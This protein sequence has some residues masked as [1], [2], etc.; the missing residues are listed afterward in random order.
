[1]TRPRQLFIGIDIGTSGVRALAVTKGGHVAAGVSV[2]MMETTVLDGSGI[3]EQRPDAWWEAVSTATRKLMAGLEEGGHSPD[4]LAAMAVDGTSG[5]L[6][7]LDGGGRPLRPGILYNDVRGAAQADE[8]N[9]LAGDFCRKLGYRF[10]SSY[11]LAKILWVQQ[12]EP[13]VFE[14]TAHLAHPSDYILGCLTGGLGLSDYS[15]AL[16]TG[17][18]LIDDC[19]PPWMQRLPG[20]TQRLP[21]VVPPGTRAGEVSAAAAGET[22]LP[23]GLPVFAGATD[24][25]TA[26]LASGLRKSGDYNTTLGTTLVFK[27]LCRRLCSHPQ[28]LIYCHKLPGGFWLPGAAS[29]TGT[30]WIETWFAQ[31]NIRAVDLAA[32]DMLPSPLV[33]YPLV[34]KGERFPFLNSSAE[35]FCVPEPADRIGRYTASLQGVAMLERMSYQVLDETVGISGGEVFS[36]GGGSRSD[37]WMQCRADVTG[38]VLHRPECPESAFGSAVL[39]AAG[40]N[41]G[42]LWETVANMVHIERTFSP[43]PSRTAACDE[44]FGRFCEELDRRGYR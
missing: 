14:R 6:V 7:C 23:Q 31:H 28:G 8:I 30:E 11:A 19:W 1:M 9:A 38:R 34:R 21:R 43:N 35:G 33:A 20:V 25:T 39:A 29:N 4:S 5:T 18:D 17:Y 26:C 2:S 41:G 32:A 42:D 16:K 40:A 3:H 12:N 44:L 15:N 37:V 22:G 10:N 36:T 24:G 13:A 27:G